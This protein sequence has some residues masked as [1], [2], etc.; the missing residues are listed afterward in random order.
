MSHIDCPKCKAGVDV[1]DKEAYFGN[2]ILCAECRTQLEVVNEHPL[3]V[4]E[5]NRGRGGWISDWLSRSSSETLDSRR[6]T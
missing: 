5:S 3:R 2:R 4:V 1:P 6:K